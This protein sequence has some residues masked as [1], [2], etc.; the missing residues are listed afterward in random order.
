MAKKT[1]KQALTLN[2]H[3][4]KRATIRTIHTSKTIKIKWKNRLASR[5]V[6]ATLIPTMPV[7]TSIIK[8]I[9]I[10]TTLVC[11]NLIQYKHLQHP[12]SH[13]HF[14][15]NTC[16]LQRPIK[17][18]ATFIRINRIRT[19]NIIISNSINSMG[20]TM[21]IIIRLHTC[22]NRLPTLISPWTVHS[23]AVWVP[24]ATSCR[25]SRCIRRFFS[26]SSLRH[27]H[28]RKILA[29]YIHS[30][31][32]RI[33]KIIFTRINTRITL[34]IITTIAAVVELMATLTTTITMLL[35]IGKQIH[36][37]KQIR[38]VTPKARMVW[39]WTSV[40]FRIQ[41]LLKNLFRTLYNVNNKRILNVKINFNK[42][43][44]NT[45]RLFKFPFHFFICLEN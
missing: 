2:L 31:H 10:A 34:I 14:S 30:P 39:Y 26:I 37:V 1:M 28:R 7:I 35:L 6:A 25:I 27:H 20:L 18:T 16:H 45:H 42:Q 21:V 36:Q 32:R 40:L 5:L 12:H 44:Q 15:T 13:H 9:I 22:H 3:L 33:N 8:I 29:K 11:L 24:P 41:I 23:M 38:P 43:N 17:E 19:I 4:K